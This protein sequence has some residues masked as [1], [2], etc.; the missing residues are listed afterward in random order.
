M[1]CVVIGYIHQCTITYINVYLM[2]AFVLLVQLA[3]TL[4]VASTSHLVF[5]PGVKDKGYQ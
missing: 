3:G 5:S 4:N 1:D 2:S